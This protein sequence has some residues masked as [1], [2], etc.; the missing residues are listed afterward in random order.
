MLATW[1]G[2][3]SAVEG[4]PEV[5]RST[6]RVGMPSALSAVADEIELAALGVEGAGNNGGAADALGERDGK[7]PRA[8]RSRAARL[9]RIDCRRLAAGMFQRSAMSDALGR[10]RSQ[11]AR[12]LPA[13][14]PRSTR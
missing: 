11:A 8:C 12:R 5:E 2:V 4:L 14:S 3:T 10:Q 13:A 6:V 7:D 1:S 9:R